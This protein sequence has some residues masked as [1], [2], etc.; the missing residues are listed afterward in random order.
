MSREGNQYNPEFISD[1]RNK[2]VDRNKE[3]IENNRRNHDLR[4]GS[5]VS[6]ENVWE[7]ITEE[8]NIDKISDC[9]S[10]KCDKNKKYR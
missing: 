5:F 8:R 2:R 3:N 1:G 9:K 4:K 10:D 7:D 6:P